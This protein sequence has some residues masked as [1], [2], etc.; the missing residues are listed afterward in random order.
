M[1]LI[2]L[3]GPEVPESLHAC[4]RKIHARIFDVQNTPWNKRSRHDMGWS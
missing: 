2:I 4:I 1:N 3:Q